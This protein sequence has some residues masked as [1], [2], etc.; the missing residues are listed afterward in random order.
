VVAVALDELPHAASGTSSTS[1]VSNRRT[2]MVVR[3][4]EGPP[5][6]S[7]QS[8]GSCWIGRDD[9]ERFG[10]IP[11]TSSPAAVSSP[12][13]REIIRGDENSSGGVDDP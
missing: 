10:E 3:C 6:G 9:E 4:T 2:V 11:S 13:H 7:A 5:L 12:K 8:R 1:G